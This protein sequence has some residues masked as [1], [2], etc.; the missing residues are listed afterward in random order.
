[1]ELRGNI[2]AIVTPFDKEDRV[3]PE[4]LKKNIEFMIK[5]IDGIVPCGTTGE[6]PTL[7][8]EEHKHV[9][10][11]V[12]EIVDGRVPVIAGTGSN[13]T[14]EAVDLTRHA[15]DAGADAALVVAPYYNKPTQ[16]G[17]YRHYQTIAESCDIPIVIYN[18]PSR[19]GINIEPSTIGELAKLENIVG[20][21]EASGNLGQMMKIL[22]CCDLTL[23]S[24]D[25]NLTL[26]VLAIGGKGVIS[27]AS[28]I[29]PGPISE[30]ITAF[31]K[32]DLESAREINYRYF[33]LFNSI[34][35]ETNPGPIKEAM[36][37][38]GLAAGHVRSPLVTLGDENR[39][40]LRGVLAEL[41]LVGG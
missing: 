25:D 28:N 16:R 26:P 38:M 34:F 1:M 30:M 14:I 10:E 7:T 17:I 31:E 12:I 13:S 23:L 11:L 15:A 6:S 37:M 9:I 22:N 20:V 32:G 2:P 27:V 21:K 8:F 40:R 36:N 4:G 18:I 35:L 39:E 33:K 5:H 41:D 24:G 29:I 19:T 3:D